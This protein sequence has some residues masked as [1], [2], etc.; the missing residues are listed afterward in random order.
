MDRTRPIS[1]PARPWAS[2][3]ALS[4]FLLVLS[5]SGCER[6]PANARPS[7]GAASF[8]CR[9]SRV[10]DGDTF[11][12]SDGRKIRVAGIEAREVRQGRG[13]VMLD[14]GCRSGPSC[15]ST[16]GLLA[17]HALA[18]LF[19]GSRGVGPHGHLLVKG[20]LLTC[21]PNGKT[22][23]R[24]AAFCTSAATG[25]ISCRMVAEGYALRINRHWNGH[26]CG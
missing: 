20:P 8:Q 3:A 19:G 7:A 5:L 16:S 9:P 2:I 13:G 18:D 12:C 6:S 15:P 23:D 22:H 25:D 10:W 24:Q 1:R 21:E 11:T 26:K 4:S 14:G 17:R